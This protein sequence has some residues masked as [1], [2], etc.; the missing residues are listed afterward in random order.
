MSNKED[1]IKMFTIIIA[2]EIVFCIAS[3]STFPNL[4]KYK[5][6]Y[7]DSC[8]TLKEKVKKLNPYYN[9]V[10]SFGILF[11][12][13]SIPIFILCFCSCSEELITF[14]FFLF[15]NI[16]N[17]IQWS[18]TLAVIVKLK[19]IKNES[20]LDLCISKIY[21]LFERAKTSLILISFNT[22]FNLIFFIIGIVSEYKFEDE[23]FFLIFFF[24]L[25]F[26]IIMFAY[27]PKESDYKKEKLNYLY[28]LEKELSNSKNINQSLLGIEVIIFIILFFKLI[29][30]IYD[31]INRKNNRKM[32]CI[33]N[34][35]LSIFIF[36]EWSLSLAII[37]KINELRKNE[38]YKNSINNIRNDIIK[39]IITVSFYLILKI[40]ENIIMNPDNGHGSNNSP[41]LILFKRTSVFNTLEIC[42]NIIALV[43]FPYPNNYKS[44]YFYKVY[45]E[46]LNNNNTYNISQI[47]VFNLEKLYTVPKK[48]SKAILSFSIII[49]VI[50]LLK[51]VIYLCNKCNNLKDYKCFRIF[52][53]FN[54]ALT[55]L[56]LILGSINIGKI[57]AINIDTS[58]DI[59]FLSEK[60]KSNL[61]NKHIAIIILFVFCI[62]LLVITSIIFGCC[63]KNVCSYRSNY[64]YN[65][66]YNYRRSEPV[67]T[68]TIQVSRFAKTIEPPSEIL[69]PKIQE[70]IKKLSEK[71]ETFSKTFIEKENEIKKKLL[72]FVEERKNKLEKFLKDLKDN[73]KSKDNLEDNNK[74]EIKKFI[75]DLNKEELEIELDKLKN[76][77]DKMHYI[78]NLGKDVTDEI[79]NVVLDGLKEKIASLPKFAASKIESKLDEVNKYTP[80][81]FL[82]SKFGE[83]LKK[84]L[85]KYGLSKA[86]LDSF[87]EEL[88]KERKHRR[89]KE[90]EELSLEK[91]E[92][93]NEDNNLNIDLF[94]LIMEE[95][96]DEDFK[97]TINKEIQK[98]LNENKK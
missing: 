36:I 84:A 23:K 11:N 19:S 42:L 86:F 85:E 62:I 61:A 7:F 40:F 89:E 4:R 24:E 32:L 73:P 31:T 8:D 50:S 15:E 82:N 64:N 49:L 66:N 45:N 59:N 90:R 54:L 22:L 46:N 79:K 18:V 77:V 12:I 71:I 78:F 44:K 25:Y 92:F 52:N 53:Y 80:K 87:K 29:S 34:V 13:F 10:L 37:S 17:F 55:F 70:I 74:E 72:E 43:L 35:I 47:D 65:Y 83:P 26:N 98:K 51:F 91:N 57:K 60:I 27:L 95:Y 16:L 38:I 93:E 63:K 39:F 21:N 2:I 94:D 30:F 33:L 96:S 88:I 14:L 41:L 68:E 97:D 1:I 48:F 3:L 20:G 9:T 81:E 67:N 28:E 69:P 5:E 6:K 76:I 56:S 75:K 58:L